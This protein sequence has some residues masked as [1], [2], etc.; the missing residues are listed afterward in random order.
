[1]FRRPRLTQLAACLSGVFLLLPLLLFVDAAP[2][3][4]AA[5]IVV[6]PSTDLL[7]GQSVQVSGTGYTPNTFIGVAMC[8]PGATSTSGCDLSPLVTL[9][10]D[11]TG[12]FTTT[13]TV[14]RI[15]STSNANTDCASAPGAC[16]MAAGTPD[17]SQSATAPLSFDP[18]GPFIPPL[19]MTFALGARASIDPKTN[20]VTLSGTVTCSRPAS[21]YVYGE[22]LQS[23]N[24]GVAD[25][26]F[27]G[28]V[29]CDDKARVV[30]A[31]VETTGVTAFKSGQAIAKGYAYAYDAGDYVQRSFSVV[32]KVSAQPK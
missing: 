12:S 23:T 14:R 26:F 4:A 32:V 25:G 7:D 3:S 16:V 28:S 15:I 17:L 31:P 5:G 21:A 29:L 20:K 13:T 18:N 10:T 6:T 27:S 30:V 19:D 22:L 11:A 8:E 9:T 2:A 24:E 1:M